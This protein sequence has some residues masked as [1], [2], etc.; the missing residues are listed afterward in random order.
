MKRGIATAPISGD[1]MLQVV[2]HVALRADR[3][4]PAEV[5]SLFRLRRDVAFELLN[6]P[7]FAA[8]VS[9]HVDHILFTEG[10]PAAIAL[11]L[12]AV[13]NPEARLDHR[14]KAASILVSRTV[15]PAGVEAEKNEVKELADLSSDD[16]R[17]LVDGLQEQLS[18]RATVVNA[19]DSAQ[20]IENI[21]NLKHN[22]EN[23][24]FD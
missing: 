2:R 12:E 15:A 10:K 16:L 11:L 5:A 14:I 7:E 24:V 6:R 18:E 9:A 1:K 22:I 4:T 8:M 20:A 21:S 23:N 3:V 19:Q 13:R 17:R